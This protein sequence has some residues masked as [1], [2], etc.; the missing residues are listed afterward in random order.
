[1]LGIH[2]QNLASCGTFKSM[3]RAGGIWSVDC[4]S[5]QEMAANI[6]SLPAQK[7]RGTL[8]EPC[9]SVI[10]SGARCTCLSCFR[11]LPRPVGPGCLLRTSLLLVKFR[12]TPVGST[13]PSMLEMAVT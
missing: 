3:Q 13:E 11:K 8:R 12:T 7:E 4:C 1:M 5:F 2:R 10:A 9:S 6:T